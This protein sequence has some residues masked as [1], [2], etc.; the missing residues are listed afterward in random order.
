MPIPVKP[1]DGQFSDELQAVLTR[2]RYREQWAVHTC[3]ICGAQVGAVQVNGKW[4]PE[5]HWPSVTYPP[6]AAVP[7]KIRPSRRRRRKM[8]FQP[9][10]PPVNLPWLSR[11]ANAQT[12]TPLGQPGG[13][14]PSPGIQHRSALVQ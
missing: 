4:V 12:E 5:Q 9:S 14:S 6:R 11:L 10:R 13:V 3:E 8:Q 1:C 2:N 7:K